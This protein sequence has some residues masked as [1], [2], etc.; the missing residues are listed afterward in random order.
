[1]YYIDLMYLYVSTEV[2]YIGLMYLNVCTEMDIL[3]YI[4]GCVIQ[5]PHFT[6]HTSL[7]NLCPLI[8]FNSSDPMSEN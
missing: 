4:K 2:H 5:T 6:S 7:D 8:F 1:M 3:K